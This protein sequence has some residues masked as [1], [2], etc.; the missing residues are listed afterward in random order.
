MI[1][2]LGVVEVIKLE[3]VI[4]ATCDAHLSGKVLCSSACDPFTLISQLPLFVAIR[5]HRFPP[6]KTFIPLRRTPTAADPGLA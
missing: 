6:S 4:S 5:H 2:L 3:V 1:L